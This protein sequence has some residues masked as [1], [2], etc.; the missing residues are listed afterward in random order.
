MVQ[1]RILLGTFVL[2][3]A[4]MMRTLLKL[5]VSRIIRDRTIEACSNYEF[6]LALL[7]QVLHL[8]LAPLRT[9]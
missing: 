1:R 5:N 4:I 8:S 9:P 7:A 3:A 6:F 2:S